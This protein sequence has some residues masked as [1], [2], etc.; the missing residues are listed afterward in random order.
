MFDRAADTKILSVGLTQQ[1][2]GPFR[3]GIQTAINLDT[4]ESL[5]TDYTLEYSRRTYGI[6]LRY[7]PVQE[8]GSIGLRISDF[9]WFGGTDPFSGGEVR[10]VVGGVRRLNE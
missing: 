6:I 10:P 4:G 2:Y 1:I 3:L 7:N 5:S 8:L 9:N